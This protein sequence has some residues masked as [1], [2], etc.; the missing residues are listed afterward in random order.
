MET[1]EEM[2]DTRK[3]ERR[4]LHAGVVPELIKQ[5]TYHH[6]QNVEQA[7]ILANIFCYHGF[8]PIG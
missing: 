1:L 6:A 8:A 4:C 5:L 2:R 3:I 7:I